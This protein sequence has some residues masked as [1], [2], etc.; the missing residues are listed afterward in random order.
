MNIIDTPTHLYSEEFNEDRDEVIQRAISVGVTKFLLPSIDSSQTQAM[1]DLEKQYPE[2]MYL[3]TG[4]HPTYVKENYLKELAHIE[5]QLQQRTFYAIGE[6]G[7]DLYW[8]KTFLNEQIYAFKTQIKLAK[9][10]DLP[11][12]I[13]CREAFDEVFQVL[14]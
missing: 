11:I 13:H 4:L 7:I 6:I 2:S 9:Q 5:A 3:M 1:Y 8:D 14:E 10:Y 12:V